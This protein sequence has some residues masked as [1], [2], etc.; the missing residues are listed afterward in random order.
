MV[1]SRV[2]GEHPGPMLA[3]TALARGMAEVL[4]RI[5]LSDGEGLLE[6]R[7]GAPDTS[8]PLA[9]AARTL[10]EHRSGADPVLTHY[11]FWCGNTLWSGERMSGVV[12]WSGARRGR[13][14]LTPARLRERLT[15]WGTTLLEGTARP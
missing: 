13:P 5:H 12:D 14:D 4:A 8:G 15:R 10:P 6:A 7:V 9:A 3:P 1:A 11:D 2:P